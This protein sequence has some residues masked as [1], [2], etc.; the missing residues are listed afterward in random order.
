MQSL[1]PFSTTTTN[2]N[3]NASPAMMALNSL[4]SSSV[5]S[6]ARNMRVSVRPASFARCTK[7]SAKPATVSMNCLA[8]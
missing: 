7:R 4:I 1:W 2:K 5:P 8:A 6:V 3:D